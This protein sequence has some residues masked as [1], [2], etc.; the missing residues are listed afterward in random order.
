M[1]IRENYTCPLEI[2]HD[3]MKGK[4]KTILLFQLSGG[5]RSLSQLEREIK[6]IS[7]K[8]LL[9]QLGELQ[10]YGLVEKHAFPGYP[11]RVEYT[12]TAGRGAKMMEAIRIMQEIG[13][14][15]LAERAAADPPDPDGGSI[16][17]EK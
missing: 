14:G 13:T 11:L 7:Q 3:I 5:G 9:Q 10:E 16:P 12:L 2:V 15:Y 6:G 1:K 4:W 17:T 8:M